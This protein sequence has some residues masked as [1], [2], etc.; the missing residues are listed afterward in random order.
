MLPIA[1]FKE[2]F[3]NDLRKRL[4]IRVVRAG[5]LPSN[6]REKLLSHASDQIVFNFDTFSSHTQALEFMEEHDAYVSLHRTEG[7]GLNI[8]EAILIG[9]RSA[10]LIDSA[11][12]I[13]SQRLHPGVAFFGMCG[14]LRTVK[15]GFVTNPG[16][17]MW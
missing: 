12:G 13:G 2:A 11:K 1:A 14:S 8:A 10:I 6:I 4:T 7:L 17:L 15:F 5:G 16:E 3:G 9:P